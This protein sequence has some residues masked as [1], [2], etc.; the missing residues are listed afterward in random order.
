MEGPAETDNEKAK[1]AR[2]AILF[3]CGYVAYV[4]AAVAIR[5][6]FGSR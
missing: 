5:I 2:L 3:L 4:V 6:H 1:T